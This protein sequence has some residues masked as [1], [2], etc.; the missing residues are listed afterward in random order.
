MYT[1]SH[2]YITSNKHTL[3]QNYAQKKLYTAYFS[4]SSQSSSEHVLFIVATDKGDPMRSTS[5]QVTVNLE[6]I[7]EFA[8]VFQFSE[9]FPDGV[10]TVET[11][12]S[13]RSGKLWL[14]CGYML[15]VQ[16]NL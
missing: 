7:N 6:D 1:Q 2:I 15:V 8:P 12:S 10:Y 3:S 5:V 14:L 4:P 11:L 9:D 16:W 13:A